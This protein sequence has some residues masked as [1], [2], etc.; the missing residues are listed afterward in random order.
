MSAPGPA[1][2]VWNDEKVLRRF[3]PFAAAMI[4]LGFA[5]VPLSN[6]EPRLEPL[7]AA[8]VL[9]LLLFCSVPFV[10][11]ARLPRWVALLV[12]FGGLLIIALLRHADYGAAS[13]FGILVLMPVLWLALYGTR[14]ELIALLVAI[15]LMFVVP[16]LVFGSPDYPPTEWRRAILFVALSGFVGLL[17]QGLVATVRARAREAEERARLER[18]R[19]AYMRA[20]MD[21]AAE[22][23]AALDTDG[24]ATFVNPSGAEMLGY[25][26]DDLVGRPMHATIHHSHP[27]G[28]PYP[29]EDCPVHASLEHGSESRRSDEVFWRQDGSSFP[30]EYRSKPIESGEE[31]VGAVMTF[32]DISERLEVQRAKDEFVSLVSHELR[33]PLTSIRGSLGLMEGGVLG[34]LPDEVLRMLGIAISNTDRLVRLINDTLDAERIESGKTAMERRECEL[35]ELMKQTGDLLAANAREA[36]VQLEIEPLATTIY[37]DPDRIIQTLVN[38]VGNAIKFSPDGAPVTVSGEADDGLVRVTVRDRGPGIPPDQRER[39]FDRFSQLDSSDT[40]QQPG[41]GLGLAIARGIVE[42]HGGRIWVESKPG[43]G[44]TFA[45]E[46]PRSGGE[47]S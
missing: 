34:E 30:V 31:I 12:P 28:S 17:T 11:W 6:A 14:A 33:T 44:S 19:E 43:D 26:V 22:G 5:T 7:I 27:D 35:G 10:P 15:A 9:A 42:Q 32:S 8:G 47:A 16:I 38:L 1:R 23:I 13:G 29:V 24:L 39:I 45:F 2:T 21:S 46:I 41:S 4:T 25:S 36:G 18:R 40:R 3:A 20:V 37:A